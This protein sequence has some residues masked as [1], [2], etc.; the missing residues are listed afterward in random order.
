MA[1]SSSSTPF[2]WPEGKRCAV[3]LSF[4]DARPS[5]L[6]QGI[7]IL[8]EFGVRGSFY[9]MLDPIARNRDAWRAAAID[10][11]HE[12][13]NHTVNH[14]CSGNYFWCKVHLEDYT[15]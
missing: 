4:D 2:A 9:V 10:Y 5:Q 11:G 14:P 6:E 12:I 1:D 7:P 8:N 3:S 13:G 15:L